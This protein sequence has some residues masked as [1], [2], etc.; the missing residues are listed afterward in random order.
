MVSPSA[1]GALNEVYYGVETTF[2]VTGTAGYQEIT[3]TSGITGG[4]ATGLTNDATVYTFTVD[5]DGGGAATKYIVGAEAQ[6][7]TALVTRINNDLTG[8]TAAI[9]G[10]AIRITSDSVGVS[11]TIAIVDVTLAA[12]LT[13]LDVAGTGSLPSF[14]KLPH[15][16][17][18]FNLTKEPFEDDTLR[19]D[20]NVFGFRHGNR[21]AA[22]SISGALRYG[23]WED[24]IAAAL[25]GDIA[26][27]GDLLKNG[28]T[29]TTMTVESAAT[30]ISNYKRMTGTQVSGMTLTVPPTG[31]VTVSFDV[32][33]QNLL[34][35]ST[36]IDTAT[37][38]TGNTNEQ[39]VHYEG[40]MTYDGAAVA[41]LTSFS[42]TSDVGAESDF[43]LFSDTAGSISRRKFRLTGTMTARFIDKSFADN[44]SDEDEV[45]L[46][47]TLVDK[48]NAAK[49]YVITIP[50]LKLNAHE[51]SVGDDGPLVQTIGWQA[52][53]DGNIQAT[54]SISRV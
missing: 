28:V 44:Y 50:R 21:T 42:M 49:K 15:A 32:L 7:F 29:Q 16:S 5:I 19:A 17:E 24:W 34:H 31:P 53:Y 52:Y 22:G 43:D 30:D 26:W 1:T 35:Y 13:N 38:H 23:S 10:G 48:V 33:S 36:P 54:L 6:T 18:D 2:G 20:G 9:V 8:A 11:S 27:T 4:G 14:L 46:A 3:F 37:A 39:M 40:S 25:Y 47:L 12:A 51:I 45:D 41:R